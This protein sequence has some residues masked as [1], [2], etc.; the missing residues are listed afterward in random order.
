MRRV[1]GRRW[2][3]REEELTS[4]SE[5]SSRVDLSRS[6]RLGL[7]SILRDRGRVL[8]VASDVTSKVGLTDSLP[9]DSSVADLPFRD[10]LRIEKG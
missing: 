10:G 7:V 1:R 5:A 6:T 4:S 8:G 2:T 9:T 3:E